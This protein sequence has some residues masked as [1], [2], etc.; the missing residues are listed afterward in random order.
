MGRAWRGASLV[1]IAAHDVFIYGDNGNGSCNGN[2]TRRRGQRGNDSGV[3]NGALVTIDQWHRG[4]GTG[5]GATGAMA[6]GMGQRRSIDR[7]NCS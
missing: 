7:S 6:R 4:R 2:G 3:G 1:L 5:A